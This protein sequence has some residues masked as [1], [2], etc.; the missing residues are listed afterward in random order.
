[1]ASSLNS[2]LNFNRSLTRDGADGRK[3]QFGCGGFLAATLGA[4]ALS[5]ATLSVLKVGTRTILL[6]LKK[7][8]VNR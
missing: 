7:E 1:V 6:L 4:T 8:W 3:L 5:A 2:N